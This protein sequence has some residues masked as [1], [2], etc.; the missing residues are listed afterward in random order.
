MLDRNGVEMQVGDE[1]LCD[2][3]TGVVVEFGGL[4][5]VVSLDYDLEEVDWPS[6]QVALL[7]DED[8]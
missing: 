7:E 4:G 3:Q 8:D 6:C 2:G 5:V 1:V